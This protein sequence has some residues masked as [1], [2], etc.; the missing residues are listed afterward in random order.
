MFDDKVMDLLNLALD[1]DDGKED[2]IRKILKNIK[3]T[4]EVGSIVGAGVSRIIS[5]Y[6]GEERSEAERVQA[7]VDLEN[8]LEALVN[9]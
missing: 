9:A 7:L 2:E 1:L 8:E 5:T 4:I 3:L 6:K